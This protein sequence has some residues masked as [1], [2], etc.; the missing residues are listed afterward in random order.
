[1]S[2]PPGWPPD[3]AVI[4][5]IHDRYQREIV[6]GLNLCP[7]ARRSREQGRVHRPVFVATDAHDPSPLEVARQLGTLVSTHREAEIVLLTF[8]IP[9]G[10][11]WHEP[12]AFER[13]LAALRTA[14]SALP[15]PR[16]FYMVSFHPHLAV[17]PDRPLTADSLVSILRRSPDPVIQ[18]VD[19]E[20]LDR[21]RKQAQASAR[22]RMLRELEQQ[23]P[24][25][26]ALFARSVSA[27]PELS[28][29]I[30]RQNFAAH[31]RGEAQA[32]L[33]RAITALLRERDRNY[34]VG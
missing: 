24:A 28:G 18:C 14:W 22:E 5:A 31:G 9:P 15:P 17:P 27:D 20:L 30:A 25:L 13:F 2:D 26:A 32:D 23:D 1:M 29:D 34:G 10:H 3:E 33:E 6:E 11:A 4:Q 12:P 16:Q 8:P 21:V 19:A 7:F